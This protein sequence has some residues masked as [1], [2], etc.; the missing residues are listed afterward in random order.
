MVA[1]SVLDKRRE[2]DTW[3]HYRVSY[4]VSSLGEAFCRDA[5]VLEYGLQFLIAI[6][7]KEF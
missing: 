2:K 6:R 7:D 4:L 5:N 1:N 3:K